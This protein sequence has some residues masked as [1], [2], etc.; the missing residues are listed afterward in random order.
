MACT[1]T[2]ETNDLVNIQVY[3]RISG[4]ITAPSGDA[5]VLKATEFLGDDADGMDVRRDTDGTVL[6]ISIPFVQG[7]MPHGA[8]ALP[9][10][11][12]DIIVKLADGT[13]L[14]KDDAKSYT[15]GEIKAR[16]GYVEINIPV[17]WGPT[18]RANTC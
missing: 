15:I 9:I 11:D 2:E 14:T 5:A 4:E 7:R 12:S 17:A 6:D 1:D 3:A 8:T 16:G 13:I 10:Q 18:G